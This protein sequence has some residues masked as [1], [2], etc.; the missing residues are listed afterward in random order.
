MSNIRSA[1]YVALLSNIVVFLVK[2]FAS[3]MTGSVA[4]LAEA[5]RSFSDIMN[6]VFLTIGLNLS[7]KRPS[8]K[9]PFGRGKEVFFGRLLRH[10]L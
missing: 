6:Q 10:C 9:Y 3:V 4:M 5:P 2:L 1:T 8:V 7:V